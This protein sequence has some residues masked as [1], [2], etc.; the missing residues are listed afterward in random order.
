MISRIVARLVWFADYVEFRFV[1]CAV[2]QCGSE[3][4]TNCI[5]CELKRGETIVVVEQTWGRRTYLGIGLVF[6]TSHGR[7]HVVTGT[8]PQQR[9]RGLHTVFQA[10]EEFLTTDCPDVQLKT[11]IVPV[12]QEQQSVSLGARRRRGRQACEQTSPRVWRVGNAAESEQ[13]GMARVL[14]EPPGTTTKRSS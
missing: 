14:P 13:L 5:V 12:P 4:G 9:R 10:I 6:E 1:D 2:A 7:R 3:S 11:S 8:N